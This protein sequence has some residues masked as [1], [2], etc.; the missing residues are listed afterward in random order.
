MSTNE[1]SAQT[2]IDLPESH[3]RVAMRWL[4]WQHGM[5]PEEASAAFDGSPH[6]ATISRARRDAIDAATFIVEECHGR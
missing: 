2:A 1:H 6:G 3:K 5:T 4:E